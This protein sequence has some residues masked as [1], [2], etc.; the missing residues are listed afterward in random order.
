MCQAEN[1]YGKEDAKG[2]LLVRRKTQIEQKP[3]DLEVYA[4][5]DA[6]FTCSGTTDPEEVKNLR[7]VWQKDNKDITANDQ[8]MTT[9]KQDNSLT[10]SGTIVRDSGTYTCIA[11]NGLDNSSWPAMLTVKGKI[12]VGFFCQ[13]LP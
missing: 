8:R 10:I 13:S 3:L 5:L 11:T 12:W 2:I 1:R 6:K 9:N 4:G 7:I